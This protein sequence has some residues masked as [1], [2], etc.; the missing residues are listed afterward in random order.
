MGSRGHVLREGT[1]VGQARFVF[2]MTAALP[3]VG[4]DVAAPV[5]V[6]IGEV[7]SPAVCWRLLSPNNRQLGRSADVFDD[8]LSC[9]HAVELL[10]F[11]LDE[12]EPLVTRHTTPVRWTW[13][14]LEGNHV[15]AMSGRF[16]ESERQAVRT[17][18]NFLTS[19]AIASAVPEVMGFP[20]SRSEPVSDPLLFI[21]RRRIR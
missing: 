17:L 3:W 18:D 10:L 12:A 11:G 5:S 19:A 8:L 1:D 4:H 6:D 13:R 7:P 20:A 15:V 16:F 9:V 14:V 2:N 21:D